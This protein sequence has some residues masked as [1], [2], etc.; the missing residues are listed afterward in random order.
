[1]HS[2]RDIERILRS[3]QK[4]YE[5]AQNDD[6]HE[7]VTEMFNKRR[8]ALN[9]VKA[10]FGNS[11]GRHVV[12]CPFCGAK[13]ALTVDKSEYDLDISCPTLSKMSYPKIVA[14]IHLICHVWIQV[15]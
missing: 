7:F 13:Q 3:M 9:A 2:R 4:Q 8:K 6:G 15:S 10:V 5:S 11:Y 12:D 1:M 14:T